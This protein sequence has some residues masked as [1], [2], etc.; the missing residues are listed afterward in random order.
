M[1]GLN[2]NADYALRLMLEIGA[3]SGAVS[4]AEIA[5]RQEIPYQ[6]LRKVART[7]VCKG[8]LKSE[9]GARGG[10]RLAR[11]GESITLLEII[12]AFGPPSLNRCTVEPPRC[13]RREV[14]G[15]F[16]VW[17]EAQKEVERVLARHLL[18]EVVLRQAVLNSGR[19]RTGKRER[20]ATGRRRP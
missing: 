1:F 16:P 14:C 4:T 18:S 5:R 12:A 13:D 7:L 8:L 3:S 2:R 17:A 20:V 6:F 11:P 9:R 15:V 19:A 10:L